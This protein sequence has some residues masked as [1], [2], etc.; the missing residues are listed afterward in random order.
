VI[1]GSIIPE[2][3]DSRMFGSWTIMLF[4]FVPLLV[5]VLLVAFL[6]PKKINGSSTGNNS[7]A[8]QPIEY[9]PFQED[10]V[11]SIQKGIQKSGSPLYLA[12]AWVWNDPYREQYSRERQKQRFDM[13]YLY[14]ISH[15]EQWYQ[16]DD[17]LSYEVSECEWFS[18]SGNASIVHYDNYTVCDKNGNLQKISLASNNLQGTLAFS[19]GIFPNFRVYDISDNHVQGQAPTGISNPLLEVFIVSNNNFTGNLA[20][21]GGFSSYSLRV[22][23]TSGNQI[24]GSIAPVVRFLPK[25]EVVDHSS[26]LLQDMADAVLEGA[27]HC[28]D[29]VEL[30][31]SDTIYSG[32][33]PNELGHLTALRKLDLSVN[34]GLV[35]TIPDDLAELP[36]LEY[37]DLSATSLSGEVPIALCPRVEDGSLDLRVNCSRVVCCSKT[38]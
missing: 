35:G 10:L 6:L 36:H 34:D 4:I 16:D 28:P 25:L 18:Q 30:N 5:T 15:G 9:P 1:E 26:T 23:K 7:E 27:R 31:C 8:T 38:R 24:F 22:V 32:T 21:G 2:S 37:L 33:L 20:H 13:A 11:M 14:Y 19:Q 12:N 3:R 17:W 29:L